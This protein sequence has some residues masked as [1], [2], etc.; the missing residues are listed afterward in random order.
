MFNKDLLNK[1]IV[2]GKGGGK[3][4]FAINQMKTDPK[5][6][7]VTRKRK[8]QIIGQFRLDRKIAKQIMGRIQKEVK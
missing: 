2:G 4:S 6:L 5:M 7:L 8:K 3:L 1:C